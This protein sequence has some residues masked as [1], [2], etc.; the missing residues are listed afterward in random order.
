MILQVTF[1]DG[2]NPW[3]CFTDDRR[4]LA[5]HWRD[6]IKHHPREAQPVA[7]C[8]SYMCERAEDNA[9]YEVYGRGQFFDTVKR[10]KHLG[11]ALAALERL[12]GETN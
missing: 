7:Y 6:W 4:E 5:E 1:S 12:G 9:G 3:I 10:Y 2:S 8:G 11:R